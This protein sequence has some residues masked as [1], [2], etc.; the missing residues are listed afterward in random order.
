[1]Y[2]DQAYAL[3]GYAKFLPVAIHFQLAQQGTPT[4]RWPRSFYEA[5]QRTDASERVISE[6]LEESSPSVLRHLDSRRLVVDVFS[7]LVTILTPKIRPVAT[8]LLSQEEKRRIANVVD[9]MI[10]YNMTYTPAKTGNS[11]QYTLSPA[12]DQLLKLEADPTWATKGDYFTKPEMPRMK[13]N[14]AVANTVRQ[15]L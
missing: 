5:K 3:L 15:V 6:V 12:V 14:S 2:R 4:I 1:M 9:T 7:P 11:F 13:Q 10:S 8:S